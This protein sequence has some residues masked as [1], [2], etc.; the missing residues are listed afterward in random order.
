M[1]ARAGSDPSPSL[2]ESRG[3]MAMEGLGGERNCS[4][5]AMQ[6]AVCG[7]VAVPAHVWLRA[8]PER[9]GMGDRVLSLCGGGGR[10]VGAALGASVSMA[11]RGSQGTGTCCRKGSGGPLSCRTCRRVRS[12]PASF[13]KVGLS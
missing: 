4:V 2:H 7:R 11:D 12:R 13:G 8:L 1:G 6:P 3:M 5:G 10:L 9:V